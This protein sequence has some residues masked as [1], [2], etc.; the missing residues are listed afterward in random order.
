MAQEHHAPVP[1]EGGIPVDELTFM[2]PVRSFRLEGTLLK[3]GYVSLA[4]EF[5]LR[6][7]RDAGE[8]PPGEIGAFFG[9]SE[10]ET[11]ALVQELLLDGYIEPSFDRVCLSNRGEEAFDPITASSSSSVS[12]RSVTTLRWT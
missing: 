7:L 10:R 2:V 5:A 6:L 1:P 8:L 4:T 3:G 9:F 12:N 11:Q